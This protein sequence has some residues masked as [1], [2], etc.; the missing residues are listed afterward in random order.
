MEQTTTD[1]FK[2]YMGLCPSE[3]LLLSRFCTVVGTIERRL[4][5]GTFW[6][7]RQAP[8]YALCAS[9]LIE[10]STKNYTYY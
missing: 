5:V 7:G 3:A 9:Y 6:S 2:F 10:N 1:N 4:N 8:F